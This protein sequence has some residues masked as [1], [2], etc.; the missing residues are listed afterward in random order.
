V[1]PE[2]PKLKLKVAQFVSKQI[3]VRRDAALQ[4]FTSGG[5][6]TF[7]EGHGYRIIR[8]DGSVE[9]S[10]FQHHEA[11]FDFDLDDLSKADSNTIRSMIEAVADDFA[12]KQGQFI[13]KTIDETINNAGT[14]IDAH[15][16]PFSPEL[17][18]EAIR[19]ID[20]DFTQ[21]EEPI[22]PT[23]VIGTGLRETIEKMIDEQDADE[24]T[25]RKFAELIEIKR[26]DWND[27][28]SSRKLVG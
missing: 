19:S 3:R 23:F 11:K 4:P 26:K 22:L 15:G 14:A 10:D 12:M 13:F 9:Q 24:I 20:I 8:E 6:K 18:L 16:Q 27:R 25:K 28:E 5:T 21:A 7:F 2:Y 1:L 17:F